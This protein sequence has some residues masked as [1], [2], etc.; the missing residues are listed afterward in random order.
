MPNTHDRN[1]SVNEIS[2]GAL[3]SFIIDPTGALSPAIDTVSSGGDGPAFATALSTDSVAILNYNSG[4]GR[5][6]PTD[7]TDGTRFINTAPEISFPQPAPPNVSHP[8]MALQHGTEVLVPDLV[9]STFLFA[10]A[11]VHE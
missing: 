9:R 11:N 2:S 6:I 10:M 7:P 1:S 4:N 5:I 3:Q 8:H